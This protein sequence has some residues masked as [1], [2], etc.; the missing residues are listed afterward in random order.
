MVSLTIRT[1]P[2]G[3]QSFPWTGPARPFSPPHSWV[4]ISELQHSLI[5]LYLCFASSCFWLFQICLYQSLKSGIKSTS[6]YVITFCS[7]LIDLYLFNVHSYYIHAIHTNCI[8]FQQCVFIP[9]HT[10]L[11][12]LFISHYV[13]SDSNLKAVIV[14]VHV[15]KL[16]FPCFHV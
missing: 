16:D 4:G 6:L 8:H 2:G 9:W 15:S 7:V 10:C 1:R 12:L 3:T 14:M 13:V 11:H 5:F